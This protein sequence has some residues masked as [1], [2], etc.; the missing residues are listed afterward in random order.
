M[1]KQRAGAGDGP[2]AGG[3][4]VGVRFITKLNPGGRAAF[5]HPND[6]VVSVLGEDTEDDKST[7][8]PKLCIDGDVLDARCGGTS[9]CAVFGHTGF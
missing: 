2:N 3:S 1:E 7:C 5:A 8:M 9:S 6:T 4:R